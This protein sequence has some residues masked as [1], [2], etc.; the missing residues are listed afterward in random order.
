[1]TEL[2]MRCIGRCEIHRVQNSILTALSATA[3][4][5]GIADAFA[6]LENQ[7]D[8]CHG[9]PRNVVDERDAAQV[10]RGAR[11]GTERHGAARAWR[12]QA[13]GTLQNRWENGARRALP[14]PGVSAKNR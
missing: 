12:N 11:S 10:T 3:A 4:A 13:E 6:A 14:L 5:R 8:A 2:D 1:M 7:Q 9:V